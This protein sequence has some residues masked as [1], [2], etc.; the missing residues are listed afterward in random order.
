MNYLV[1]GED[2]GPA[3]MQK[4]KDY[5]IR[6][7]SEDEFL[8]LI[9]TKS[10][11]LP[12]YCPRDTNTVPDGI[13][14]NFDDK[15]NADENMK[16]EIKEVKVDKQKNYGKRGSKSVE[17][18][19]AKEVK[20]RMLGDN[21]KTSKKISPDKDTN[22]TKILK[23]VKGV[24][25]MTQSSELNSKP[26]K[27]HDTDAQSLR[28]RENIGKI[29]QNDH[30]KDKQIK[31]GQENGTPTGSLS[32]TEKYKPTNIKDIIGQQTEKS[33][34][35][36]LF[37]WLVNWYKNHGSADKPKHIKPSPWAKDDNG[38]FFKCALLSGSPGI[39]KYSFHCL[40]SSSRS[41]CDVQVKR[42]QRH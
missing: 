6:T 28:K 5:G 15:Q 1:A 9:L 24:T 18:S 39:G 29:A 34:M 30:V 20:S 19:N 37:S 23:S 8:D 38:A 17:S 7:L 2:P 25:D 4:A 42:L 13:K 11:M 10:G 22:R 33:N 27:K 40:H 12:R 14:P 36:K 16:Q 32:W 21:D 3:K 35:K 41:E 26:M 31:L